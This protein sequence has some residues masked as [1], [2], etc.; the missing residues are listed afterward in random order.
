MLVCLFVL[1]HFH[2]RSATFSV[3]NHLSFTT[4]YLIDGISY[5]LFPLC[6]AVAVTLVTAVRVGAVHGYD[7]LFFAA[8]EELHRQHRAMKATTRND[9]NDD[10]ND[11]GE[12]PATVAIHEGNDSSSSSSR[13]SKGSLRL[14]QCRGTIGQQ[15]RRR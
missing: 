11:A 5:C 8:L 2:F 4:D 6:R 7:A 15:G 13:A 10:D 12:A 3:N 1:F 9:D 14:G